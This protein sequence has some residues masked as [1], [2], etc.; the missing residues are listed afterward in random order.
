MEDKEIL[1]IDKFI[2]KEN[3]KV[4]KI[5]IDNIMIKL[6]NCNKEDISRIIHYL[7]SILSN[8]QINLKDY[9]DN[10]NENLNHNLEYNL[11]Y[12]T[13]KKEYEFNI[14]KLKTLEYLND[15]SN[16]IHFYIPTNNFSEYV[17]F[18]NL[19]NDYL[20]YLINYYYEEKKDFYTQ[21]NYFFT[22]LFIILETNMDIIYYREN[23]EKIKKEIDFL[24]DKIL[25]FL[26]NLNILCN[27]KF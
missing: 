10:T 20:N 23:R 1:E 19:I 8:F 25:N 2:N 15:K 27:N 18:D 5:N 4:K 6:K 14:L 17:K 7:S 3:E 13:Y 22:S 21:M 26:T 9:T 12:K 11:E 24:T 16:T